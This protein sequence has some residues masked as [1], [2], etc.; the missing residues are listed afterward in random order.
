[1]EA[2]HYCAKYLPRPEIGVDPIQRYTYCDNDA[3]AFAA[4]DDL[5]GNRGG[6]VLY[7]G[8]RIGTLA[9]DDVCDMAKQ[10]CYFMPGMAGLP[11]ISALLD[12]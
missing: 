6:G 9:V 8:L 12:R 7:S 11:T 10:I 2:V 1:M 3:L 5:C 4:R